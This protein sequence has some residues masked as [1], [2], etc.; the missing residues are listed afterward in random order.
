MGFKPCV[1]LDVFQPHTHKD[2]TMT[3]SEFDALVSQ[4]MQRLVAA[5]QARQARAAQAYAEE[6]AATAAS[7]A[8]AAS[9]HF[10]A[11]YEHAYLSEYL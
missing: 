2:S 8:Y 10:A 4:D 7:E 6:Q 3:Q 9:A 1:T 5:A 11:Q